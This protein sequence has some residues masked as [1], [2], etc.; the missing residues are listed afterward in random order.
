MASDRF[1][2]FVDST[3]YPT[4][5]RSAEPV[6]ESMQR[7]LLLNVPMTFTNESR[8]PSVVSLESRD[9]GMT[10]RLLNQRG[11]RGHVVKQESF[12]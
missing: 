8:Y 7:Q 10:G 12:V 4:D 2:S 11:E 3:R 1:Q 6:R 9:I 5:S